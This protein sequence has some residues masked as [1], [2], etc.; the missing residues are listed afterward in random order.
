[1]AEIM[2]A[3][4]YLRDLCGA[5]DGANFRAKMAAFLNAGASASSERDLLAAL[6]TRASEIMRRRIASALQPQAR[7]FPGISRRRRGSRRTSPAVLA[8]EH[9]ASSRARALGALAFRSAH[10]HERDVGLRGRQCGAESLD[11]FCHARLQRLGSPRSNR[12]VARRAER[13]LAARAAA[14]LIACGSNSASGS[15][16]LT[17]PSARAVSAT[18]VRRATISLENSARRATRRRRSRSR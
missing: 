1:M 13:G 16:S 18:T 2:G 17:S 3:L 9:G 6:T 8:T 10:K 7:S 15:T 11:F 14:L 5:G 12:R 4:A